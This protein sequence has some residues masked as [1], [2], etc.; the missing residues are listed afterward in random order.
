[1]KKRKD[2]LVVLSNKG[3]AVNVETPE[4][5]L[6]KEDDRLSD[7]NYSKTKEVLMQS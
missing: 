3:R 7:G 4:S 2:Q 5:Y 1:M 6:S